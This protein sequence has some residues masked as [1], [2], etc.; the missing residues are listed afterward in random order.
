M[1]STRKK[2][3]TE[4]VYSILKNGTPL[5][6]VWGISKQKMERL[7]SA[8]YNLYSAEKYE[9]AGK[10]FLTLTLCNNADMKSW[11]GAAGSAEMLKRYDKA[12]VAYAFAAN[13][14]QFDPLLVLHAFDCHLALKNYPQA[15][16]CLESVILRCSKK[17]EYND[18]K[19]RAE[20]LRSILHKTIQESKK[21][22]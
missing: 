11:L 2:L 5:Y 9:E 12:I 8:A 20:S 7:Y 22:S 1:N 15:L 18:I 10:I 4:K 21:V 6:Q 3:I 19:K 17:T 14:D 13:L 16:A